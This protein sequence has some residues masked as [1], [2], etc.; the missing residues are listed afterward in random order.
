MRPRRVD[1]NH[2][3]IVQALTQAGCWVTDLSGVGRG[4]PDLLVCG[5]SRKW[6]LLEIKD[7]DKPPSAQK[8]TAAQIKFHRDCPGLIHVVRNIKEALE[9]VGVRNDQQRANI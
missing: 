3:G 7:G 5:P 4:C 2:S 6:V 8:L 9:S 1:A